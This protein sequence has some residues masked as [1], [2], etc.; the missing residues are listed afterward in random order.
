MRRFGLTVLAALVS[1][2]AVVNTQQK[3]SIP[4]LDVKENREWLEVAPVPNQGLKF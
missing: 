2:S 4:V 3:E 1:I